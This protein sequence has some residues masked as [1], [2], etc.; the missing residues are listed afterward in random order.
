MCIGWLAGGPAGS[1]IELRT[2]VKHVFNIQMVMNM[3]MKE[4]VDMTCTVG[5]DICIDAHSTYAYTL[6]YL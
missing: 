6:S 5:P 4:N 2:N 3:N 1:S